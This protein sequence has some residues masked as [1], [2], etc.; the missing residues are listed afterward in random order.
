[1]YLHNERDHFETSAQF[2]VAARVCVLHN[3]QA[4][5]GVPSCCDDPEESHR[6]IVVFTS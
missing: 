6:S 5:T 2:S 1:M 4:D 3:A